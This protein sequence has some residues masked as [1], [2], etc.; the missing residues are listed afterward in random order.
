M[1]KMDNQQGPTEE[2]MEL[3]SMLCG[4][5]DGR[6]VWERMCV[7]MCVHTQL[8]SRVWLCNPM[9]CSPPDSSVHL[10]FQATVLE[11]VAISYC[12][13]SSWPRDQIHISSIS[14]TGRQI[15]YHCDTW[16]EW[17]P[18]SVWLS[19][20]QFS[21]NYHNIVN[22][23]DPNIKYILKIKT[24]TPYIITCWGCGI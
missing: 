23:L 21:G 4:S 24:L 1:F 16:A 14:C 11:C 20:L 12:W 18:V 7:H 5:Q 15:L 19:P 8:L 17:I 3:C 13:G 9:D 10:I 22:W 2:H 6:G